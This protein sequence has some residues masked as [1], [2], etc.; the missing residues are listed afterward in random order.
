MRASSKQSV[1]GVRMLKTLFV[2]A[3]SKLF[4][5]RR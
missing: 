3:D 1:R 2:E 4:Q 5:E